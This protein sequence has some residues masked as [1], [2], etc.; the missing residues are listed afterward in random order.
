MMAHADDK[1]FGV[2]V[3]L[4]GMPWSWWAVFFLAD[5]ATFVA[6]YAIPLRMRWQRLTGQRLA[7]ESILYEAFI[8]A[9]GTHHL[10]MPL[11]MLFG[12]MDLILLVDIPMAAISV[13]AAVLL[14]AITSPARGE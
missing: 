6:Y 3:M 11:A 2:A 12:W 5:W 7:S 4:H 14:P 10:L 1:L 8:F 9:C 13:M